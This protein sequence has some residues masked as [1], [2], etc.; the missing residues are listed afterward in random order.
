MVVGMA[1]EAYNPLPRTLPRTLAL[2]LALTL[3][4]VLT[5]ALPLSF[6]LILATGFLSPKRKGFQDVHRA[7]II[8]RDVEEEVRTHMRRIYGLIFPKHSMT[9]PWNPV[10]QNYPSF[11]LGAS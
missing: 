6:P 1:W 11:L 2:T 4:V 3:P 10:A 7:A 9:L 5:V 8:H